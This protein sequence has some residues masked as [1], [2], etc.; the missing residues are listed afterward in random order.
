MTASCPSGNKCFRCGR[1]HHVA[2]CN[3]PLSEPG[4][5]EVPR[6]TVTK[7]VPQSTV[8]EFLDQNH[9]VLLQTAKA[10]VSTPVNENISAHVRILFD[11][12]S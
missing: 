2:L 3:A 5:N 4:K 12:G 8:N 7:D 6:N 11:S 10:K 1:H 9:T